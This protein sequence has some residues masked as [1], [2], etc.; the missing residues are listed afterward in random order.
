MQDTA[1]RAIDLARSFFAAYNNH[2]V[3]R[4]IANLSNDAEL[5]YVPMGSQGQGKASEVGKKIWSGLIDAFPDLHVTPMS[6]FGDDR[7]VAAE[8]VIGGTQEKDFLDIPSQHKHYELPH[9]FILRVNE[10][11]RIARITC[12]WDNLSFYSQ[13]GQDV[14]GKAA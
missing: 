11:N 3:S 8:V 7:N 5:N 6:I 10:E 1:G 4:M 9:A 13:L 2:E 14:L 12:Y